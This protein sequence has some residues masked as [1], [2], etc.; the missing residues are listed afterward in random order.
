MSI[1]ELHT[2]PNADA[3][4]LE[5]EKHDL[6]QHALELEAYGV[7]I[8]PREKLGVSK[9]WASKLRN[10]ILS[11]CEKRNGVKIGNY[12]T[13]KATGEGLGKNSWYLLQE[14]DVFVE[15]ALNPA[16]L[17]LT[18]WLLGQSAVLAGHT[19]IIK[20]PTS[21]NLPLHSDAHGI[22]PGGGHIAHVCNVSWLGTDYAG[23]EDGPTIFAPGS[24]Q[25]GRATLP[26]EQDPT[27]TPFKTIT[28]N[29]EAGSVAIWHGA[30]W[31]GSSPRTNPGLRITL[32]QVF[33]RMHMRP[34]HQWEGEVDPKLFKRFPDLKR[35]L[36]EHLYP[37]REHNAHPERVGPF[38]Q[39]GT[40]PFA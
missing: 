32:V 25:Y 20:P 34:I 15:A 38:M 19:W 14:N 8:V 26:H 18:R 2:S 4:M 29:G 1:A 3:I 37:Y 30:T 7:T 31:H 36:G 39:T 9:R 13:S 22:P 21:H 24:H 12:R 16:A 17:A 35:L 23:P 10:A 6:V 11:T 33:M 27:T 40:D 5:L 28:L